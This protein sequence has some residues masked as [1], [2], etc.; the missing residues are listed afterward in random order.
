MRQYRLLTIG[1]IVALIV[2][3]LAVWMFGWDWTGF[4]G[5]YSTI[6]TTSTSHGITTTTVRPPG[7]TVWDWM[8]LLIIPLVLAVAA[9][10]TAAPNSKSHLIN[11]EKTFY[12]PTLTASQNCSSRKASVPH[13]LKRYGTSHECEPS[14]FYFN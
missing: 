10:P 5:G 11:K 4:N 2:F 8:Q 14:L 7:K 13:H 3:I 9:L 12:R 6:T 1:I